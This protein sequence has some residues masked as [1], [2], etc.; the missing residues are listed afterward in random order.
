MPKL[1]RDQQ[2]QKSFEGFFENLTETYPELT[3]YTLTNTTDNKTSCDHTY[4]LH[5]PRKVV[6]YHIDVTIIN[7]DGTELGPGPVLKKQEIPIKKDFKKQYH[8]YF[9]DYALLIG[10]IIVSYT[11][12]Y[13]YW[14]EKDDDRITSEEI[15]NGIIP[16]DLSEFDVFMKILV[17]YHKS[18]FPFPVPL[19]NEEK[20]EKRCKQLEI[21]NNAL[22]MNLNGLT[23]MYQ[24]R[25]EQYQCLRRRMRVERRNIE[26]KYKT[27]FEKMQKKF[28]EY[29]SEIKEKDDCPVCY[30]EITAEKLKIPG[31]CHTICICCAEKCDKCP[32]CRESY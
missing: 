10:R 11:E 12:I 6:A 25:D 13:D 22:I 32:I 15:R 29:Y 17:V 2:F 28:A 8:N 18:H 27:M 4:T 24:E 3:E 26:N 21:K 31:C 1:T 5:I 19:T 20:L 9:K 14:Y 7:S 23:N 16:T 30:E